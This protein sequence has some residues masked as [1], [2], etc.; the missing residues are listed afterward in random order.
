MKEQFN[1]GEAGRRLSRSRRHW[2]HAQIMLFFIQ[3]VLLFATAAFLVRHASLH[4]SCI[5]KSS[6]PSYQEGVYCRSNSHN[7][8]LS[9]ARKPSV[10]L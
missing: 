7:L 1:N 9:P 4:G 3:V 5:S 8:S 2:L 6:H 10:A